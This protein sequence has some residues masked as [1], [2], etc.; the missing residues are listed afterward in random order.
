ML[1]LSSEVIT[2]ELLQ[3]PGTA[4]GTLLRRSRLEATTI[5]DAT[6]SC[7]IGSAASSSGVTGW[8]RALPGIPS[9][10]IKSR[11]LRRLHSQH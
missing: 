7:I 8:S 9:D 5:R 6:L 11:I 3:S 2:A 1:L 10:T 4:A